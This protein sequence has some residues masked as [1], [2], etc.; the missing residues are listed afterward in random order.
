VPGVAYAPAIPQSSER[1]CE[2]DVLLIGGTGP[3]V[4]GVSGRPGR[5]RKRAEALER[6]VG[7]RAGERK[8]RTAEDFP[9]LL[10]LRGRGDELT[11]CGG[12]RHGDQL[13]VASDGAKRRRGVQNRRR[14]HARGGERGETGVP[15]RGEGA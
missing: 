15:A 8:A 10:A 9:H 4:A 11:R 13:A 14:A 7:R 5:A 12:K 2:V 3:T 6:L 1:V